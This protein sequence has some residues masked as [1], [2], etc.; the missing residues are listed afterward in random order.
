M[1]ACRPILARSTPN[2]SLEAEL[3]DMNPER[4]NTALEKEKSDINNA[5]LVP[6]VTG[7]TSGGTQAGTTPKGPSAAGGADKSEKKG[8]YSE[9]KSRKGN[10]LESDEPYNPLLEADALEIAL[11]ELCH[12]QIAVKQDAPLPY[13]EKGRSLLR[14]TPPVAATNNTGADKSV[15]VP[16]STYGAA[17]S[18]M[19]TPTAGT[20]RKKRW[21]KAQQPARQNT[22]TFKVDK[23][24]DRFK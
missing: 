14:P 12:L 13:H 16:T 15:Y 10:V 18:T 19:G 9:K 6:Q 17:P 21:K 5:P 1:F 24:F 20:P 4:C 22:I 2:P 23:G 11:R 8:E 3:Y 7:G